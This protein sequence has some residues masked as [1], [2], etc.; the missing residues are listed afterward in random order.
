MK[1]GQKVHF[2]MTGGKTRLFRRAKTADVVDESLIIQF[3]GLGDACLLIFVC[4][5]LYAAQ[6]PFDILCTPELFPLWRYFFPDHTVA[7]L[8]SR[9]WNP[10][11]IRRALQSIDKPYHSVYVT[12][13]HPHAAYIASWLKVLQKA[14]EVPRRRVLTSRERL[15]CCQPY[16]RVRMTK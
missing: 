9:E 10:Q 8:D 4:R 14:E 16:F 5:E 15:G 2:Y 12:S 3:A 7:S 11:N 13:L 6:R 1:P